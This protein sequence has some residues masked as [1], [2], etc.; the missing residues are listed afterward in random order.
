LV[1]DLELKLQGASYKIDSVYGSPDSDKAT[2]SVMYVN[3][4]FPTPTDDD[5]SR[6]GVVLLKLKKVALNSD[7]DLV[8][9]YKDRSG[10]AYRSS[11][12]VNFIKSGYENR[13]IQKSVLLSRYVDLMKNYLLDMR[14]GCN[15]KIETPY[16]T[17]K[18]KCMHNPVDRP[19]F[20]Y[21]K[22]WERKSCP[23]IVSSGYKK[24]LGEFSRYMSSQMSQIGDSSLQKEL[25]AIS[26]ILSKAPNK[27]EGKV[28]DWKG[29]K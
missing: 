25:D 24:I 13:S 6:G 20:A 8:V 27:T 3:T 29:R 15:D 14:R 9:S 18:Q 5:G 11:K 2:G 23:F 19:T 26:L 10:K 1:F 16:P 4:L 21:I 7:L 28:D 17:I 22:T 12:K